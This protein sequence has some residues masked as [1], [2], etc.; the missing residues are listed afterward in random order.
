MRF[1]PV[2]LKQPV[3]PQSGQQW[4]DSSFA[5]SHALDSGELFDKLEAIAV[6]PRK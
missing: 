2:A 4:V 1:L 3:T 5:D 6:V